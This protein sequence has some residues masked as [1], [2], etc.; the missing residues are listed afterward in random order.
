MTLRPKPISSCE[1]VQVFGLSRLKLGSY[2]TSFLTTLTLSTVITGAALEV[3]AARKF[4]IS[5]D[6]TVDVGIVQFLKWSMRIMATT[7]IFQLNDDGIQ[8]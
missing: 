3:W 4:V 1:R 5:E 7:S 6:E 2:A 8:T